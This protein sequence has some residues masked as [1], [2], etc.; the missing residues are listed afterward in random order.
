MK[1]SKVDNIII[2]K[3]TNKIDAQSCFKNTVLSHACNL[4]V[5]LVGQRKTL[6][7]GGDMIGSGWEVYISIMHFENVIGCFLFTLKQAEV[8]ERGEQTSHE[9]EEEFYEWSV[10]SPCS[11]SC[12]SGIQFR[13]QLCL[14]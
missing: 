12:G 10:W 2:V 11:R 1:H 14:R 8:S 4:I 5:A 7:R 13:G 9:T 6:R 3:T